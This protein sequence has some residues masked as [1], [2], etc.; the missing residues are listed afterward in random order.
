MIKSGERNKLQ[1]QLQKLREEETK[2]LQVTQPWQDEMADL[3]LK[4]E[5]KFA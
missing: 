5:A 1:N 3:A 4:V 2:F